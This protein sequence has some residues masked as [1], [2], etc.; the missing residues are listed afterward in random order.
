MV[1]APEE[2]LCR[3][4]RRAGK[5]RFNNCFYLTLHKESTMFHKM[6]RKMIPLSLL[7]I[8]LIMATAACQPIQPVN[9]A[10]PDSKAVVQGFY[11]GVVNQHHPERLKDIFTADMVDHELGT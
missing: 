8:S 10:A 4:K 9:A 11:E 7:L 2:M 5:R 3:T 1:V 6:F